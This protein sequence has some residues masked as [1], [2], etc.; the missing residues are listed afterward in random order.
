VTDLAV[1]FFIAWMVLSAWWM[2]KV[3]ACLEAIARSLRYL[4]G[5][6]EP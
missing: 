3:L 1:G 2:G 5:R 4:H 6:E